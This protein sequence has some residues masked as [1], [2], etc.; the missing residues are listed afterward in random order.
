MFDRKTHH[1]S[2]FPRKQDSLAEFPD[3]GRPVAPAAAGK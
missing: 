1:F 2:D 3:N